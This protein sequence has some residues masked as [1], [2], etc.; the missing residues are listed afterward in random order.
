MKGSYDRVKS[1]LHYSKCLGSSHRLMLGLVLV[2][3][4][5]NEIKAI[6]A[7]LELLELHGVHHHYR[8]LGTQTEIALQIVA[9]GADYVLCLKAN[10]PSLCAQGE[11]CEFHMS[12]IIPETLSRF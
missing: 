12:A 10:H 9:K 3:N 5:T 11:S 8:C 6:R 1:N 4:K 2:E 7:L